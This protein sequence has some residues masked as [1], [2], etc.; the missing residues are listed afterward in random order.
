MYDKSDKSFSTLDPAA[1]AAYKKAYE[2]IAFFEKR[3]VSMANRY[4][5]S[6]PPRADIAACDL[7][8]LDAWAK[9]AALLGQVNENGEYIRKWLLASIANTWIQIRDEPCLDP[10]KT[11]Q[12]VG[13]TRK[14]GQAA[15]ADFSRDPRLKSRQNNHLYWAAWEGRFCGDSRQRPSYVRL[16]GGPGKVRHQ[17]DTT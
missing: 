7:D 16:G 6:N 1:C 4:V 2:P 3:L 10:A 8:W 17:P 14:V 5:R 12:V 9:D 13:W 15:Q 11:Q